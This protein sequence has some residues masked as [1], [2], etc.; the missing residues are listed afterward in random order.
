VLLY[1]LE[2]IN[3][4][5]SVKEP[6]DPRFQYCLGWDDH[7]GMRVS[8]LV[9]YDFRAESLHVYC[10]D[11]LQE[12][13]ALAQH[14]KHIVGF[15][16]KSFDD[17]V[18]AAYDL[19]VRTTWDLR[20]ELLERV[21]GDTK[22]HA[23]RRLADWLLANDLPPKTESGAFAPHMWQ[24]G[25]IGR[26]IDYCVQDVMLTKR[27]IDKLPELVDPLTGSVVHCVPPW[28]EVPKDPRQLDLVNAIT[29]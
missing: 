14:R 5:P 7:A 25:E 22:R 13:A 3:C 17:K 21:N 29:D 20:M 27:L 18:V 9:A 12:F 26:V 2:I 19:N 8:V 11:N 24:Q 6:R 1:D 28:Q 10:E 23:G 15:N 16:S 4:I